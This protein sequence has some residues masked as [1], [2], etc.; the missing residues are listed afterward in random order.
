M[1]IYN[2]WEVIKPYLGYIFL[3]CELYAQL[4]VNFC[5]IYSIFTVIK[6]YIC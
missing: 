4:E 6:K 3:W 5:F 2:V 1:I